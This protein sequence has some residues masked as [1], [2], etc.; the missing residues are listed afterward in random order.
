MLLFVVVLRL[1]LVIVNGD[2]SPVGVH[3]FFIVVASL[4]W[5]MDSRTQAQLLWCMNLLA[6]QQVGSPQTRD[7]T[8][9]P[10]I[11]R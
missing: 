2:Y 3:G 10:C 5:R 6:L 8:H 11:G 9:V 4:L 7:Q 1:S